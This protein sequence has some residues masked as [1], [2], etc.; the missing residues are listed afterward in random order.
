MASLL[1]AAALAAPLIAG[2]VT[3][4]GAVP[5]ATLL[6]VTSLTDSGP[7]TLRAAV[8]A[9]GPRVIVF[10]VGGEIR[11]KSD[12]KVANPRITIAGQTAPAPVTLTGASLRL[13][14]DDIVVQHIAVRPGAA[15][16]P[17]LAGSRDAVTIGGGE[18][19]VHDIRVENASF[20]WAVDGNADIAGN[21]VRITFRDNIVAEALSRAGHPKGRHSMGM[22]INGGSQN[23]LITGN[24]FAA[25]MFRNPAIARGSSALIAYNLIAAPGENAVHFY[26]APA[27][28]PLR[29]SVIGNVVLNGPDT[30]G[31]VTAVQVP[32]GMAA[33]NPDARLYLAENRAPAGALT[34]P[35]RFGLATVMPIG[36]P[37]KA[38]AD[39][40]A[41]VLRFAGARPAR[42]DPVDA[43]IVQGAGDGTL[44]IVDDP[45]EVGGLP[46]QRDVRAAAGVP[47]A[48]FAEA[49]PGLLRIQAWLCQRSLELGADRTPECPDDADHYRALLNGQVA[50]RR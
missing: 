37:L 46:A 29:A 42:R 7:G 44:R 40:R 12:L 48:P 28:T 32:R 18:S 22:L 36:A 39:V 47:S 43:R 50:Q 6:R 11:L 20:S 30:D 1:P 45:A 23:V 8:M 9:S 21:A 41:R 33:R 13:R 27:A 14:A 10:D 17:A 26:D 25:N 19:P 38:P 35:G 15:P 16:V 34:N 4:G 5:E 49:G 3:Q 31:N 24:L 2:A